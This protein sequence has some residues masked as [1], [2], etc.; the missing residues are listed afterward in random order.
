MNADAV[1]AALVAARN[2]G[3]IISW[4]A[5][6]SRHF[7]SGGHKARPYIVLSVLCLWSTHSHAGSTCS[8][9]SQYLVAKA[10]DCLDRKD[11]GCAKIKVDMVIA[12]EPNCAE[13]LFIKGW[14]LQYDDEK[15]D[16]GQKMQAKA[17]QL[18]PE[19][20]E[21]WEKRGHF[22]ESQ[23]SSQAFSHFD[24]Q[25]YGAEDRGKAWEAVKYLNEMHDEMGSIFGQVPTQRIPVIVF[26]T[27]EF[28]DAWRAPFIGGFFDRRDGKIRIRVDEMPGGEEEF[29]HR[30]RHEFTHAFI[31]QLYPHELPAWVAEGISEF[32]ARYN[33][34]NG[35]WKAERLEQIRK[36]CHRTPR[37]SLDKIQEAISKKQGYV[38]DIQVAYLESEALVIY[39]SKERG[40][41]W[42]PNV[43]NYLRTHGGTFEAAFEKVLML[44]PQTAID[45]LHH[46][47]E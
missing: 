26:T 31:Y 37:L 27:E 4:R 36:Q 46:S 22:I 1:G 9:E 32:Y 15:I 11:V 23:L 5:P 12:R 7:V 44:S 40:D 6:F 13:A 3:R 21:F 34:A 14:I 38:D 29:R 30:T 35:F 20:S 43:I 39:V 2:I 16:E 41:S 8:P 18:N 19:L 45:R 47:W 24:L 10:A 17:V 28:M 33:G 42:I 25:F